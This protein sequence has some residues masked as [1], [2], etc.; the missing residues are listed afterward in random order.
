MNRI[1]PY[2][3]FNGNCKEAMS[4]YQMVLGGEL[5]V[6]A[7][8]D[9]PGMDVPPGAAGK[10]MHAMLKS[11]EVSLMASDACFEPADPGDNVQLC[12]NCTSLEQIESRFKALSAGGKV[13]R[14]LED[15]FWGARFGSATDR[16]GICWLFNFEYPKKA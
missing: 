7:F 4:F 1:T 16:F 6:S 3:F 11:P 2:L 9:V 13:D 14:G 12:L 8:G 15:T 5:Q 10:V